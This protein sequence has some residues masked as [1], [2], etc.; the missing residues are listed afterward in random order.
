MDTAD[1]ERRLSEIDSKIQ[2]QKSRLELHGLFDR[3]HT[4]TTR[5]LRA[6]WR[7]LKTQVEAETRPAEALREDVGVVERQ[8]HKWIDAIDLDF[9]I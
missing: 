3:E 2:A 1:I 4:A 9:K 7:A 6:R 8:V 5:E